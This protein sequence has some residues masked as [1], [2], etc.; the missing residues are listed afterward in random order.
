MSNYLNAI[1]GKLDANQVLKR[2]YDEVKNR[3][4]VDAEVTAT[5]GTVD[6][7]I[8]AA[9]GDNIAISDGVDTLVINPNGSINIVN[10]T[11]IDGLKNQYNEVT[12]VGSNTLTTI[13]TKNILVDTLLKR[14]TSAGTNIAQYEVVLNGGVI[15]KQYTYFGN[16][17]NLEFDFNQGL[18][19]QNGDNLL[20][21]VIHTRP[22]VGN[23]NSNILFTES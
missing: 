16:S 3:L 18:K 9:G 4:R 23:F 1:N 10:I 20:V 7:A 2:A 12:S 17:L 21:R 19:L 6:V 11:I 8:D 22:F 5:I 15:S 13:I 14:I